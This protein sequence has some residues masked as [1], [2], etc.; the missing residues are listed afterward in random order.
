VRKQLLAMLV[1][2]WSMLGLQLNF[3]KGSRGAS[4]PWI[5]ATVSVECKE[6]PGGVHWPGVVAKLQAQ[7]YA[8]LLKNV[9]TVHNAKGM[10]Q[11]KLVK[12]IAGQLSWASG[13]ITWVKPFNGCLW[14]AITA[15]V[16][17]MAET[18]TRATKR[19]KRPT[20]LFFTLRIAQAIAWILKLLRGL[21]KSPKGKAFVVQ[22]WF[23][24]A[25]RVAE[26]RY[27][28]R[29]DASPFGFGAILFFGSS[30][31]AWCADA[32]GQS[33]HAHLLATP[34]DAAWQAEWELLAILIAFDLWLPLLKDEA[35]C[36][37]QSDA[38]AAL[39]ATRRESGR[40]PAMNA[41]CAEMALRAECAMVDLRLEHYEGVLNFETDALSRLAQGTDIPERL[42]GI[43]KSSVVPR[44]VQFFW[45]WPKSGGG[46]LA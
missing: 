16:Q 44:S 12:T 4:V 13:I 5:G 7:K 37:M 24:L 39:F 2:F 1:L 42:H 17:E 29:T 18:H 22:K 25:H 19:K 41:L 8:E 34:G 11:L 14:R 26:L 46:N 35:A 32:W 23:S 43:S 15:H 31:V 27:T 38:T 40:T 36:L 20:D 30:P 28:L 33:D 10:I 3:A 6:H 21:V 45:A 9:E